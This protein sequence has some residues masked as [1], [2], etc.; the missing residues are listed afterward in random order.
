VS[1]CVCRGAQLFFYLGAKERERKVSRLL[2]WPLIAGTN[3]VLQY[4]HQPLQLNSHI[5]SYNP[6]H[7]VLHPYP[8]QAQK[9]PRMRLPPLQQPS[10]LD[11]SF[12]HGI[13]PPQVLQRCAIL[14]MTENRILK[15][16]VNNFCKGTVSLPFWHLRSLQFFLE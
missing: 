15:G 9:W 4:D 6:I 11:Y 2:T 3:I 10:L 14:P 12:L 1:V 5:G 13:Q 8:L 16:R 7:I